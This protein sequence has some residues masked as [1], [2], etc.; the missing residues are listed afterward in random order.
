MTTGAQSRERGNTMAK[1]RKNIVISGSS[2]ALGDQL[3]L[4]RDKAGRTIL[5]AKPTFPE[6]REF[7]Q[8]QK[9]QMA[10]FREA[11]LYAKSAA[12]T[13]AIYAEKAK[14]TPR[15]GFNVAMADW[16]HAPEIGEIDLSGWTGQAGERIRV[17]ALDD[18]K[19]ERVTVLIADAED[20]IIEQGAAEQVDGLWWVYTT[21]QAAAGRP[22]VIALAQDLPGNIA[23]M[24]AQIAK[25]QEAA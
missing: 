8:A 10:A 23:R 14:D 24:V 4:K 9:D 2:G 6:D 5:S 20:V 15:S 3:V 17:K 12:R 7:T 13:E 11:T 21:T 18:V 22:K 19:V 25:E 1:V 16:F